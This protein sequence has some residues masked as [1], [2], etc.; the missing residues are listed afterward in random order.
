ML[1][2][3]LRTAIH[4]DADATTWFSVDQ[5]STR[6][7]SFGDAAMTDVGLELMTSSPRC[8]TTSAPQCHPH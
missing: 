7:R 2:A 4:E 1:Y 6:F 3:S 8:S 5:P